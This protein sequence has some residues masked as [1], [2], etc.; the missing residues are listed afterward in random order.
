MRRPTIESIIESL[1]AEMDQEVTCRND[2]VIARTVEATSNKIN[3]MSPLL[4][5]PLS[6]LLF[7]FGIHALVRK[8]RF[9]HLQ[10]IQEKIYQMNIWRKSPIRVFREFV[11]FY[12]KL[13]FFVYFSQGER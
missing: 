10:T 3:N 7:L 5:G 1:I 9:F 12:E 4:K 8:G 13:S 2:L 11:I 6:I